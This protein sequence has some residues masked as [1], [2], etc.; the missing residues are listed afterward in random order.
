MSTILVGTCD[1]NA[2]ST[3]AAA[4][5]PL[6]Q[7]DHLTNWDAIVE[8]IVLHRYDFVFVDLRLAG[9]EF[10]LRIKKSCSL[11]HLL[12]KLWLWP[13]RTNLGRSCWR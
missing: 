12:C 1:K 2:V 8:A 10:R 4:F 6:K 9:E 3:L 13:N 11:W 7:F 5:D